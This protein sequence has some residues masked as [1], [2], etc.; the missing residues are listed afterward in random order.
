MIEDER[1]DD[2]VKRGVREAQRL[3]IAEPE[4]E[5][6][7]IAP[8]HG[9]HSLG[10]VHAHRLGPTRGRRGSDVSWAG[11]DV[12]HPHASPDVRGVEE[13]IDEARRDRA[14]YA[15][16]RIRPP[17]PPRRLEC[18]ELFGLAGHRWDPISTTRP[19]R[20]PNPTAS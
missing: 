18:L 8:R 9:E 10:D 17:R 16:V 2:R 4:V 7:V 5:P 6:R 1:P 12:E 11:R 13:G 19:P 3:R 15:A 20:P 14:G